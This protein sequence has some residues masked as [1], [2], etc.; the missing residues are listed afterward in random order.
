MCSRG[1][2]ID[3][4][5]GEVRRGR[6]DER[7]RVEHRARREAIRRLAKSDP[8]VADVSRS[9][10]IP[11]D[12]RDIAVAA[13]I[14]LDDYAVGAFGHRRTGENADAGARAHRPVPAPPGEGFADQLQRRG[15]LPRS[16]SRTA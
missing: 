7:A 8:R 1:L 10:G 13:H 9:A 12:D 16:A 6:R 3:L 5:L 4:H 11:I 15:K 2:A 14:L